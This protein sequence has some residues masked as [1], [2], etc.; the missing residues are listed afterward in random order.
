MAVKL[1]ASLVRTNYLDPTQANYP[2]DGNPDSPGYNPANVLPR[3]GA[4]S[5]GENKVD[6]DQYFRPIERLH[7]MGAHGAGVAWGLQV[8][9]AMGQPSIQIQPGMALDPAGKHAYLAVGGQA[10]IGPTADN[11]GVNPDLTAVTPAGITLPTANLTG[12]YFVVIQWWE[13][14]DSATF[15]NSGGVVAQF[16]D[17]PWLRLVHP[18]DY[19]PDAQVVLAKVSLDNNGNVTALSYGDIGGTQRSSL[20]LPAQT[21]QFRRA[22]NSAGPLAD[23]AQW[24]ELRS[25]EGGG[26]QMSVAN[27][28]DAVEIVQGQSG[29]FATMTVTA[30]QSN[31]GP[32]DN[33]GIVLGGASATCVIGATSTAGTLLVKDAQGWPT[34]SLNG[35][36]G[37][38]QVREIDPSEGDL[39]DVGARFL[40][41][42][43]WDLALDGRSGNNNRALVDWGN[44][45][46]I[47]FAGDYGNGVEINGSGLE[48]DGNLQT[49]RNLHVNG[50]LG[51]DGIV[52]A[53]G[54]PLMGN[55]ARKVSTAWL[56]STGGRSTQD[57]DLGAPR[58]FTAFGAITV[59]NSTSDFDYDNGIS[60]EVYKVDGNVTGWF[61][62]GGGNSGGPK[63][64]PPGDDRN[65]HALAVTGFG[66][67]ITFRLAVLGP[68][69]NGSAIGVVFFE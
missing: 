26:L 21:V 9:A 34:A 7:G 39:I 44:K 12:D 13:T 5:H 51:V 33:P 8:G 53:Q 2:T 23:S 69:M 17:T 68:D 60:V 56:F 52:S 14:F 31:F 67:V 1:P 48:V 41:I 54:V 20:S 62:D 45:L 35:Q 30:D 46:I 42:H 58:Q 6:M 61:I 10:E 49:D 22:V 43:G 50:N 15:L 40:H 4:T 65:V 55:P 16:N 63:W 64:G 19:N 57:V 27:P 37:I 66:Q 11:P 3:A 36:G 59:I 38:A 29:S 18:G 25:R 28:V 47:N 24:G 32:S